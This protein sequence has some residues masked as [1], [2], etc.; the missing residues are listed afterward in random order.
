MTGN[1]ID[2]IRL[3]FKTIPTNWQPNIKIIETDYGKL[4][5]LDTQGKKTV[6]LNIPDGPNVIEHHEYLIRE[7]SKNFRVICFELPGV[8]FSHPLLTHDYSLEKSAK[9]ILNVMDILKVERA[10]L[11]FSCSNGF[12][13]MKAAKIAPERFSYMFLS[14][15]I[16]CK[17]GQKLQYLKSLPTQ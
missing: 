12:Y 10:I 13:A 15:S 16:P 9:I 17:N 3:K 8:G 6:I 4:R 1:F 14:Q 7:L 2:K 5:V 11:S